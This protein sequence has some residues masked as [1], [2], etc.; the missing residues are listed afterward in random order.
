MFAGLVILLAIV[1]VLT[2][3]ASEEYLTKSIRDHQNVTNICELWIEHYAESQ[4]AGTDGR[5]DVYQLVRDGYVEGALAVGMFFSNRYGSGPSLAEIES[6]DY[7]RFPYVRAVV[8]H[9]VAGDSARPILWD[10]EPDGRRDGLLLV[11]F[12]DGH[13]CWL[14]RSGFPDR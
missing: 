9:P 2:T 10:L 12:S 11:G 7:R 14:S 6:G 5:M 13:A 8:R 4:P 1:Y 3:G